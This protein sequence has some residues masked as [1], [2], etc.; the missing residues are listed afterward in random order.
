M[1]IKFSAKASPNWFQQSGPFVRRRVGQPYS[2]R[3]QPAGLKGS[4]VALFFLKKSPQLSERFVIFCS[5]SRLF[6]PNQSGKIDTFEPHT[7]RFDIERMREQ[8][9][10]VHK[11][12]D[13]AIRMKSTPPFAS[14]GR[15]FS[16]SALTARALPTGHDAGP[17]ARASKL[18]CKADKFHEFLQPL[19]RGQFQVLTQQRAIDIAHV[20]V[21]LRCL[22]FHREQSIPQNELIRRFTQI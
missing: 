13:T 12:S 20:N 7:E 4:I 1:Q 15:S 21:N 2:L 18:G 9:V 6:D 5:A 3:P 11:S 19:C 22:A 10:A 17:F 16:N 14:T 8:I